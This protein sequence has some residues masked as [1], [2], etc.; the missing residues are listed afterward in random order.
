MTNN[1]LLIQ[2]LESSLAFLTHTWHKTKDP[3]E[4]EQVKREMM[5]C[6]EQLRRAKGE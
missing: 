6:Q 2:Q 4:S 1:E 5:E 3:K